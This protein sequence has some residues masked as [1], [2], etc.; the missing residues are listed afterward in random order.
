MTETTTA[1]ASDSLRRVL[2]NA[3]LANLTETAPKHKP[4]AE[5]V[6]LAKKL[7]LNRQANRYE[8]GT[9]GIALV[10]A[11]SLLQGEEALIWQMYCPTHYVEGTEQFND[12]IF[13]TIPTAVLKYWAGLKEMYAFDSFEIWTTERT[14]NSD[15]L[16][17]GVYEGARYLLARWGK[18]AADL[19]SYAEV[20]AKICE[21]LYRNFKFED[22]PSKVADAVTAFH[23]KTLEPIVRMEH[24][25]RGRFFFKKHCGERLMAFNFGHGSVVHGICV[26]CGTAQAV[27]TICYDI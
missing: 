18:E 22:L 13:D 16:L 23:A 1:F 5:A 14:K 27:G 4:D 9:N 12:Y 24:W 11:S 26:G 17:V 21:S 6:E 3:M 19:I 15:P 7:G 2:G 20:R 25:N 10:F 8:K